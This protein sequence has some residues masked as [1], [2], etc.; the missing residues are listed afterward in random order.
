MTD[1]AKCLVRSVLAGMAIGVGGCVYLGCDVKWVGAVLF[2]IGLITIFSFRLDLY[3]GKVGY[4]FD[5]KPPYLLYLA[6]VILGNFIGTLIIGTMMPL[7][8]A[9]VLAQA[10]LSN[11][12]FLPVL[13]KGVLCG[14]LMFIAA[15]TYKNTKSFLP[16]LFCVPVFILAGFEHSIADMFYMCSAGAFSMDSLVFILTVLLG[17]GIGGVLIPVC[18]KWM[19]EDAVA[20]TESE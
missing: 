8:A 2:A 5:N 10:K 15:D 16:T 12:E 13:F 7:E 1:Y 11:Y 14:M 4:T 17:N 19:Y 20:K 3:T 9:E 18:G 6:V